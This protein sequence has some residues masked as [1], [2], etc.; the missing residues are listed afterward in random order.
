MQHVLAKETPFNLNGAALRVSHVSSTVFAKSD[1]VFS[2]VISLNRSLNA[3]YDQT[4]ASFLS[5]LSANVVEKALAV[6]L[7]LG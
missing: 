5:M 6:S 3:L 1:N 4:I 7:P 2:S